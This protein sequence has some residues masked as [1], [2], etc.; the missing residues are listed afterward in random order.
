MKSLTVALVVTIVSPANQKKKKQKRLSIFL[1][2]SF[3]YEGVSLGRLVNLKILRIRSLTSEKWRFYQKKQNKKKQ[4][5]TEE[6]KKQPR[7]A[8]S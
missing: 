2:P 6:F 8:N 3:H 5:D 7:N 1:H 4:G